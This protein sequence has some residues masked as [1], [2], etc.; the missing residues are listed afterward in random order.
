MATIELANGTDVATRLS[1][2]ELVGKIGSAQQKFVPLTDARGNV[3]H[4][5]PTQVVL[6]R[7][8]HGAATAP[9]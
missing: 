8:W 7:D 9:A 5:N 1:V 4:V 2:D 3:V 6:V